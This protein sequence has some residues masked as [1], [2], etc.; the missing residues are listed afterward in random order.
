M[1]VLGLLEVLPF[2]EGVR[3]ALLA[4]GCD[5]FGAPAALEVDVSSD[6]QLEDGCCLLGRLLLGGGRARVRR[7]TP[8]AAV[9]AH[10][11]MRTGERFGLP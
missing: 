6:M 11:W 5:D 1:H 10:G 7:S 4:V 8:I 3:G 2:A 9:S